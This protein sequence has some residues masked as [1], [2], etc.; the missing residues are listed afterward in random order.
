MDTFL[1]FKNA[2]IFRQGKIVLEDFNWKIKEGES[3]VVLGNIASG[4]TTLLQAIAGTLHL[5]SG[6][7]NYHFLPEKTGRWDLRKH[8]TI[9]SF[10]NRLIDGNDLYYQQRYNYS[11]ED[12]IPTVREHLGNQDFNAPHFQLLKISELLD[13]EL[14]KLSNGQTRRVILAKTLSTHPKLL[15]LDN[16][17]AGLDVETRDNL[18]EFIQTLVE[19]GQKI[20]LSCMHPED[21]PSAFTHVL[22]LENMMIRYQGLRKDLKNESHVD[23]KN[24]FHR[25]LTKSGRSFETAIELKDV[26]VQY[27]NKKVLDK[28]AWRVLKNEKWALLGKNGAGKSTLLSLLNAD[29][30]QLYR[31]EIVLFDEVRQ[32]GQSIWKV[33]Q[34]IGFFSPELHAYFNEDLDVFDVIA[35]GY[36]D[37]FIPKNNISEAEQHHIED[38][39]SF[40]SLSGLRNR[41][42]LQLSSGEQR[43]IL[44]LRSLVKDVDLLIL[45]EPFQGF[46]NTLIE[47]SRQLLD[48]YCKNTTLIFVTHY[49]SEIPDCVNNFLILKDGRVDQCYST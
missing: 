2:S 39:L 14:I 34:R 31:N 18:R 1:E 21:V 7:I 40:Y 27:G 49:E 41:K 24:G 33:K 15:L 36:T 44:F 30:P 11:P 42:Y 13:V 19:H 16:P 48:Q 47:Q 37:K 38:L 25:A 20:I 32:I 12:N 8:I 4:K 17:F 26:S 35:T 3:W 43:L 23:L 45:D 6:E 46:D 10:Q 22:Q 28:I 5:K 29:N 9:L